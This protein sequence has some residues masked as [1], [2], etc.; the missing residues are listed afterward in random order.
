MSEQRRSADIASGVLLG[1]AALLA[2]GSVGFEP[3]LLTPVALVAMCAGLIASGKYRRFAMTT[4]L[5]LTICFVVGATIA[6]WYS[7]AIY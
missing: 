2:L 4:A 5:L 7:R 6:V 1:I 3:F